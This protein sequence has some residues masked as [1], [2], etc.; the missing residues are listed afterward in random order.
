MEIKVNGKLYTVDESRKDENLLDFLRN[1]LRLHSVKKGCGTGV[2]GTCI[3][4]VDG[5][6][7]RSCITPLKKA[8]GKDIITVEALE[9]PDGTLHPIQQAF[10]DAGAVQCGFCTPGMIL[11][12]KA[13]LDSTP[14]PGDDEIKKAF[15]GNLC[16]CTGY[17]QIF[18]AVKLASGKTGK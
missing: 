2:C 9:S 14:D 8:D 1:D 16:R 15:R 10:I 4:L 6:T 12:A 5:K 17:V 7:V 3:V 13:L 11:T 18:Q